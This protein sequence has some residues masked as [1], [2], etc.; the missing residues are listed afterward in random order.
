MK[1]YI[2]ADIE[3]VTG[4]IYWDETDDYFEALRFFSFC[5]A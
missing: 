5:V 2:T 4:A 3:G 1:I